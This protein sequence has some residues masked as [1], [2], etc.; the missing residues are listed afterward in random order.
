MVVSVSATAGDAVNSPALLF[1][2]DTATAKVSDITVDKSQGVA[3]GND[4]ITYTAI[5]TDASGN[6]VK[7]QEVTWNATPATANLS[8]ATST[9]DSNGNTSVTITTLKAGSVNVTA[10]AGASPAWNAPTTTFVGDKA[11]AQILDLKTNKSTALANGTD[12]ITFTG[13]VIDA[14]NNVLEGVNVAWAVTPTTGVLSTTTSASGN[15]GKASVSLTSSQVES[16]QVTATVNGKDETSGN[17]SF[18]ADSASASLTSL[19]SDE[20]S[21][22]IAGNGSATLTAVVQDATGHPIAGAVVNWSSDNTTGNFSET[23]STTNSEGKAIVTFS[24][25]HAQLTTITASSVNN[26]Q[27]TVQVTIAP[28]TQSAQPVTVSGR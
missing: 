16:Y 3:N 14:N 22:L 19:T 26:S 27:K 9:T 4:H 5:V 10:Q 24:G 12:S 11:T 17:V 21:N 28:D 25:T 15:D 13:T 20:T 7:D 18:T 2:A 6:P 23:T 1:I 8:S